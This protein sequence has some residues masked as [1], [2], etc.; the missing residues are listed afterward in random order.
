MNLGHA[1]NFA[2][3]YFDGP[4]EFLGGDFCLTGTCTRVRQLGIHFSLTRMSLGD[5]IFLVVFL[6]LF[7]YLQQIGGAGSVDSLLRAQKLRRGVLG[8]TLVFRLFQ[9]YLSPNQGLVRRRRA[10]RS[11]RRRSKAP[12]ASSRPR[13]ATAW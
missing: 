11:A 6:E 3:H 10:P 13:P 1:L 5:V 12:I 8:S 2:L 4:V 9:V 7:L